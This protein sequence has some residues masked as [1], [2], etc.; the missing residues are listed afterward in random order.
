MEPSEQDIVRFELVV[1]RHTLSSYVDGKH[2]DVYCSNEKSRKLA[3]SH[4]FPF[5]S[6][7]W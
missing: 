5:L 7:V 2:E 6:R 3:T 4:V 1:F